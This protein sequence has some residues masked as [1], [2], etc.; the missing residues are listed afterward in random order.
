[1]NIEKKDRY[2]II[3]PTENSFDSFIEVLNISDF[4]KQHVFLNF[5]N[6]FDITP[7]QIDSLS[8]ISMT[9][10]ENGTSFIVIAAGIE[11]DDLEDESLSVV[12]TITEAED[13]LEMDEIE[14]DLGF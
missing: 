4:E 14:R 1:M 10:K 9:K 3:S 11:I 13:T 2:T 7:A 8:E 12:P 5:L 6:S